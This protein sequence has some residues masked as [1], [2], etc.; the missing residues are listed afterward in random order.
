[1]SSAFIVLLVGYVVA[2]IVFVG[3]R[4][5]YRFT[6]KSV[7]QSVHSERITQPVVVPLEPLMVEDIEDGPEGGKQSEEKPQIDPKVENIEK[8]DKE[9]KEEV[10]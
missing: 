6:K 8:N 2:L 1:M 3:E 7:R 5:V 10:K 4:I 9:I